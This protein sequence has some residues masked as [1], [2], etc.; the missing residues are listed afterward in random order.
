[1]DLAQDID[2]IAD[3]EEKALLLFQKKTY[4]CAFSDFK[5]QASDFIDRFKEPDFDIKEASGQ[6]VD[7]YQKQLSD[8]KGLK[9]FGKNKALYQ[10]N[11]YLVC[12]VLPCFVELDGIYRDFADTLVQDWNAAFKRS[13]IQ[14][15]SFSEISAGF[16]TRIF[17]AIVQES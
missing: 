2:K 3:Y 15:A 16:V 11:M 7:F 10:H 1:M 5:L 14:A 8:R 9:A 6:F 17:G 13:H 4:E 12:Y